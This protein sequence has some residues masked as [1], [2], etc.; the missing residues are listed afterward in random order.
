MTYIILSEQAVG[1]SKEVRATIQGMLAE[2]SMVA[3]MEALKNKRM[4]GCVLGNGKH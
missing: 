1:G 2:P 3:V 4:L